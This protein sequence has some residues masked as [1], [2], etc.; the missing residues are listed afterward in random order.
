M[1]QS[2]VN[3]RLI[4]LDIDYR[5]GLIVSQMHETRQEMFMFMSQLSDFSYLPFFDAQWHESVN[6]VGEFLV[7]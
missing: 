1:P 5:C 6:F 7:N 4:A 3:S 2:I